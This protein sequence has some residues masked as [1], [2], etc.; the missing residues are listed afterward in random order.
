MQVP[1]GIEVAQTTNTYTPPTYSP[2]VRR[3][4][5]YSTYLPTAVFSRRN[6]ILVLSSIHIHIQ[7]HIWVP[8]SKALLFFYVGITD[9][10]TLR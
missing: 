9:R 1:G 8:S 4:P 2:I 3:I 10:I 6:R 7:S 5:G